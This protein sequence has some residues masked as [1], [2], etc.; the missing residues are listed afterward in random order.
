MPPVGA[1]HSSGYPGRWAVAKRATALS[2]AACIKR[3]VLHVCVTGDDAGG[4]GSD[5]GGSSSAA[6]APLYAVRLSASK[7]RA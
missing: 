1:W 5:G 6:A 2:S 4:P 3:F 7:C